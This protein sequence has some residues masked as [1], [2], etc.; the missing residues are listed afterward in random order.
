MIFTWV[1]YF[2]IL[3]LPNIWTMIMQSFVVL[4]WLCLIEN[5]IVNSL[6]NLWSSRPSF[7]FQRGR[8]TFKTLDLKI[9]TRESKSKKHWKFFS[10]GKDKNICSVF[11]STYCSSPPFKS[12]VWYDGLNVFHHSFI[13][14]S[15]M[16]SVS[17]RKEW[18]MWGK[19]YIQQ[20]DFSIFFCLFLLCRWE[21][22]FTI[23]NE[24]WVRKRKRGRVVTKPKT[25]I[26][27]KH[28]SDA[29]IGTFLLSESKYFLFIPFNQAFNWKP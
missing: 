28:F 10:Q 21:F 2:D 15:T 11:N 19:S 17:N 18:N 23:H 4:F 24:M 29:W 20:N 8:K 5:G 25:A 9:Q 6:F 14:F 12:D 26:L 7:S 27:F 13:G 3:K 1:L 22:V 16:T